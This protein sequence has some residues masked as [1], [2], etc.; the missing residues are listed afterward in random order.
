L[1]RE[2]EIF[3]ICAQKNKVIDERF[4]PFI[5][6]IRNK[7]VYLALSGGGLA[8]VCHIAIIRIIEELGINE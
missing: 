7:R 4:R 6:F 2:E 3:F 1:V 5:D 8:L